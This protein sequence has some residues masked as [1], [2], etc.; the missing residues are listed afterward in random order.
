MT[1]YRLTPGVRWAVE[2]VGITLTDG[3]GQVRRLQYPEAAIWDLLSRGYTFDKVVTMTAHIAGQDPANARTLVV[4]A[5][6]EWADCGLI[7]SA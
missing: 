6:A 2:R 3:K 1:K 4:A 5:L 7:E